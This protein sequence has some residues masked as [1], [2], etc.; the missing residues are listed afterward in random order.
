MILTSIT[1]SNFRSYKKKTFTLS[2]GATLIVGE[3]AVGK[4]NIL[5]S[6]MLLATGKSFRADKDNEMI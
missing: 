3:N 1:L 6:I 4:T 2:G 5:E